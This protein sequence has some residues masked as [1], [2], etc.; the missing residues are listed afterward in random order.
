MNHLLVRA[1][2]TEE[3]CA[4]FFYHALD[5]MCVL[6]LDG[7]FKRLNP[8]WNTHLGRNPEELLAK[9][10]LDIVHPN[11]REATRARLD[12]LAT[13]AKV[14]NFE[15]RCYHHNGSYRWLRWSLRRV[16]RRAWIC[17]IAQNVTGQKRLEREVLEI[18]D[19]ERARLGRDL[20]DG[21]CQTLAGI[22]AL[23]SKLSRRLG[24]NRDPSASA[25]A[26]EIARLLNDAITEARDL[27]RGINPVGLD[28]AGLNW[29]LKALI[30]NIEDRFPV[31]CTFSSDC[32]PLR[33]EV[34]THLYRIA[35]E[36]VN[37][38][39]CHGKGDRIEIA[40]SS[41]DEKGLL[42]VCDN[43]KGLAEVGG[44][45]GGIGLRTMHYRARQIGGSLKV[46]PRASC[47]VVVTCTFPLPATP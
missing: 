5:L 4:H 40:L 39:L 44:M 15:N 13:G 28:K 42:S 10:F 17:A 45:S 30:L 19:Q 23:S 11:D 6:G 41:K 20:H 46:Q 9:P 8:A 14:I 7:H 27:A 26:T 36:A 24:A 32:P 22:S 47:G 1:E 37:N 31:S 38:A 12:T 33:G 18:L 34:G 3:K 25:E 29:A 16:P 2:R 43:G 21:L 35:Q